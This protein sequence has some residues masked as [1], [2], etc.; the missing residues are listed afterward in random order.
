[1][2]HSKITNKVQ[3]FSS[4]FCLLFMTS[5]STES[6]FFKS[7]TKFYTSSFNAVVS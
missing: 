6:E 1:M 4:I 5:Y 2:Y 7:T 3:I